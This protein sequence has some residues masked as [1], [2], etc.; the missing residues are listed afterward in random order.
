MGGH[1]FDAGD[2]AADRFAL[3]EAVLRERA[4]STMAEVGVFRG[5]FAARMLEAVPSIERYV[6]IDPWRRLPQWNKPYNTDETDLDA[7]MAET[8]ERVAFA[9]DRVQVLRGTTAEVVDQLDDASLDAVYVDGDH[10][11]RG[12]TLDLTLMRPKVRPGGVLGG[13]DFRPSVW[14]HDRRFEPTFVFPWAVYA[15][16]A[17]GRPIHALGHH[18]F[19]IDFGGDEPFAFHDRTATFASTEVLDAIGEPPAPASSGGDVSRV[20]RAIGRRLGR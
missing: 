8:L 7:A 11:L 12:I 3:W 4:P 18:Q 1:G 5:E 17:F 6:L 9:G 10:T 20:R 13:D 2:G 14:Q 19:A 15:A 16:E